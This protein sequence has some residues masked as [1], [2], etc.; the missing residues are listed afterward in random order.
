MSP[1]NCVCAGEVRR[2]NQFGKQ[3]TLIMKGVAVILMLIH[4]L[5]YEESSLTNCLFLLSQGKDLLLS[6]ALMGKVCVAMFLLLSGYG[7]S[8]SWSR[9]R[10]SIPVTWKDGL[11]FTVQRIKK[12]L[13]QYWWAVLP[14]AVFGIATGLRPISEVYWPN[15][16]DKLRIITDLFGIN[17][18]L[19]GFSNMYNVTCWYL[20]VAIGLYLVFPPTGLVSEKEYSSVFRGITF[21]RPVSGCVSFSS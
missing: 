6:F 10:E 14:L 9:R 2:M 21:D 20:G 12:L 16:L 7:L 3:E 19:Y 8:K 17:F 4:H 11:A 13:I 1:L 15:P 18:I 5:F